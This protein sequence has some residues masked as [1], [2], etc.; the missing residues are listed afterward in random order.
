MERP[1]ISL[2]IETIPNPDALHLLPEP[3]VA[4]GNLKDPVKIEEK[5]AEARKNQIDRMALSPLTGKVCCVGVY[6]PSEEKTFISGEDE[7]SILDAAYEVIRNSHI[8]TFNGKAFDIPFIFKRGMILGLPWAT[9]PVMKLSVD[10]YKSIC[11][12]DVMEEFCGFGERVSLDNLSRFML[13]AEK[14]EID[15]AEMPEL[16]KTQEGREKISAYCI[17]DCELTWKL[18]DRMGL[19]YKTSAV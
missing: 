1:K 12:T 9:I 6:S 15:F 16:L 17:K 10:R 8:V 19:I 14:N 18:A 4:L 13:G 11:H 3:E 7:A 2:D 5:K